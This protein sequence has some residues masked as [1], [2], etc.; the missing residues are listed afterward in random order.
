[1]INILLTGAAGK[2]GTALRPLLSRRHKVVATDVASFQDAACDR[3]LIGDLAQPGFAAE[4]SRGVDAI[5]H[6]AGSVGPG[7]SFEETLDGNYRAVLALLEACRQHGI[8]RFVFAS[9]HHAIGM[10]PATG[11]Y[12]VQVPAA[13]DGFYGLSK[14]FGE[15]ACAM[16]AH[17]FNI[18]TLCIRIGNADPLVVDGRRERLWTS[19]S[20]LL[21]LIEIGLSG[22]GFEHAVVNGASACPSPLLALESAQAI[23]YRPND[24]ASDHRSPGFVP[25]D[26]LDKSSVRC[27]GGFFAVSDLPSLDGKP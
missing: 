12:D 10:L 18:K 3:I 5:V 26:R 15:A 1:M 23:G 9:S 6:L 19:M 13:P 21:Q 27:V 22:S 24:H 14:I 25:L 4:A 7:L 17:R 8:A 16:Y 11:N 2:V 20:D